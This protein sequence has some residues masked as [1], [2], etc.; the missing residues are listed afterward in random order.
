MPLVSVVLPVPRSPV[1]STSTGALRRLANSLPQAVVSS[2]EVVTKVFA[3]S[4][5]GVPMAEA[6]FGSGTLQ[7]LKKRA[8][9]VW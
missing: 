6:R 1:S 2:A 8:P 4:S 9:R 3:E 7:F 5:G